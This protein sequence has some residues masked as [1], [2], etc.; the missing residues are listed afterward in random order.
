MHTRKQLFKTTMDMPYTEQT[1]RNLKWMRKVQF[2][3]MP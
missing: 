3:D 2:L 1:L